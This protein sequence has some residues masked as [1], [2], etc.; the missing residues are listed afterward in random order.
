MT[1][2]IVAGGDVDPDS[3]AMQHALIHLVAAIVGSPI[4]YTN[5]WY[6]MFSPEQLKG[7][8]IPGFNVSCDSAA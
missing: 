6:H 2:A 3:L 1:C 7:S 5:L 8:Y 4:E